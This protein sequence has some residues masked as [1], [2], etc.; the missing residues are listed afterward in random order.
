MALPLGNWERIS[1]L[2]N[3]GGDTWSVNPWFRYTGVAVISQVEA[4][5]IAAAA[6]ADFNTKV[7]S[8]A[9][10]PVKGSNAPYASLTS[11][12]VLH[13]NNNVLQQTGFGAITPVVGTGG[14][15][16]PPYTAL[17]ATLHTAT[18]GRRFRGRMYLP[19]TAAS[20]SGTTGLLS[21]TL[22]LYASNLASWLTNANAWLPG[23]LSGSLLHS[24]VMT[25]T[26]AAPADVTSVE[27]NNKLDTQRGRENRINPTAVASSPV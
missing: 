20:V 5:S 27:F 8:P 16:C 4:N 2:G 15:I 14:A 3:C 25:Q 10:Q 23:S 12:R 19:F 24:V 17:V 7:W 22:P 26:G 21:S 9:S 13:Y 6:L 1:I 18:A 11:C